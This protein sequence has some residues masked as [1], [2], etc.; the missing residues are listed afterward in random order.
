MNDAFELKQLSGH[1]VYW[2][3]VIDS[4]NIGAKALA[5]AGEA[6]GALVA[7]DEQTHGR[8][9]FDRKWLS[10]P[11]CGAWFTMLVRPQEG[12]VK[13]EDASGLVFVAALAMAKTL[14]TFAPGSVTVKWPNDLV[15]NNHKICGIMCEMSATMQGLDWA[16]LGI[17]VNL[18][19]FE[20]PEELPWAGSFESE[21]GVKLTAQEVI[22]SFLNQFDDLYDE[23]LKNGLPPILS[24][25]TPLS[26]TLN[27]HVRVIGQNGDTLT[28]TAVRFESDG[29]LV[30]DDGESLHILRAGDVSVRGMMDYV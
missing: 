9:R 18:T 16:V 17:G 23:W 2:Y 10:R 1:R 3:P 15:S 27:R 4:T 7:A 24:S 21:T 14:N 5:R 12:R 8:G 19:G 13:T 11:G 28:G 6:H 26:A 20:F 29:A 22:S 30:V 25:L